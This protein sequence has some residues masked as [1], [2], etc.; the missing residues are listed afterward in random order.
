LDKN[1]SMQNLT[2]STSHHWAC[3]HIYHH[4]LRDLNTLSSKRRNST[5]FG[6]RLGI[7]NCNTWTGQIRTRKM[8]LPQTSG[9]NGQQFIILS[10]YRVG[11]NQK[12]NFGS[13][14]TYNQ[15]YQLLHQQGHRTPGPRTKFVD[16]II[17]LIKE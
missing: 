13:N 1:T 12:I 17:Q 6:G 4:Q 9:E 10:G 7:S 5:S 16:D 3:C 11:D 8:V 15:Q 14:N 2:N